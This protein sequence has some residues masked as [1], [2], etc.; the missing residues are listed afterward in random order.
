[1]RVVALL[2]A[3]AA[4]AGLL[5]AHASDQR[6]STGE[7]AAVAPAAEPVPAAV[8]SAAPHPVQNAETV[9]QPRPRAVAPS[10]AARIDL[11]SQ[12]LTVSIGGETVH[13]WA[14]SSGREGY[15]TP[16]GVF[17]PQWTA[18]MWYSRKYDNAPMPHSVFFTGGVAV[19]A[20]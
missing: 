11:S 20:T 4:D 3:V 18:R 14:I 5:P 9:S 10:M 6:P 8:P 13:S 19:H 2:A 15:A 1:M 12:R 16:R 7:P 17:R